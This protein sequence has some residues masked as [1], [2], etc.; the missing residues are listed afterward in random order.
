MPLFLQAFLHWTRRRPALAL[1]LGGGLGWLAYWHLQPPPPARPRVATAQVVPGLGTERAVME[2]TLLE[3]QQDNAKLR[4]TL[5]EQHRTLQQMQQAQAQAEQARQAAAQAQEQRLEALV[6]R[7]AQP[8]PPRPAPAPRSSAAA[9]AA[10]PPPALPP[11]TPVVAR[12]AGIQILRSATP[13]SFAGPPPAPT[14]AETPYLPAGSYAQG[15]LVTGVF[16]SSRSGG[17]LPVLFAVTRRFDGPFQLRGPG[18][19]PLATALP[20]EGCLILGKAQGE[21]VSSRVL[22]QLD[23][24]SCVF[25]DGA[26]FERPLKG[27][28]TGDDGTLG[29]PGRVETRDGAYLAKTVLTSLLAGASEAFALARRTVVTTPFGGTVT[30][31][32]GAIGETAGFSALAHASARLSE[33]YLAQADKLLPV[34]WAEAG[35]SARLVLQEGLALDGLPTTTTLLHDGGR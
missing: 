31:Q 18:L 28:V 19:A 16:A 15:R 12:P 1:L 22:A 10:T 23:T 13:A 21:L 14:R 4:L 25:P 20:V 26:T 27:Y 3:V 8:P 24:L 9:T 30:T 34:V 35:L 32:S 7:G 33:W 29:L 17:A 2:K 6:R 5:D 11:A